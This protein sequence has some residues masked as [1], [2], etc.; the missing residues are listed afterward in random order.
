MKL[1]SALL[2]A[3]AALTVSV[4]AWAKSTVLPDSCG[5]DK[6]TFDVKIEKDQPPPPSPAEGKALIVFVQNSG[7]R[8]WAPP[9]RFA[10]DGAWVGATK[11]DSYF[12]VQVDPGEHKICTTL[13][14]GFGKNRYIQSSVE[15]AS[16]T[17]EAGKVYYFEAAVNVVRG[18]SGS[19]APTM[20]ANGTMSGGGSVSGGGSISFALT[21]LTDDV[22]KYRLKAWKLSI[23]KPNK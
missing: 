2:L 19:V 14:P 1:K 16:I 3:V 17:A 11:G 10:M 21:Q 7:A 6:V 22:G 4:Q 23:S 18:A 8:Q 15:M 12:A 5:D 9:I 20:G 13:Q